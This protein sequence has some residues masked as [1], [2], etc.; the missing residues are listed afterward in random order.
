MCINNGDK[1]NN[2]IQWV[3]IAIKKKGEYKKKKKY[4]Y[5]YTFSEKEKWDDAAFCIWPCQCR[6]RSVST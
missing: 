3:S 1:D 6:V 5:M 2:R 4:T